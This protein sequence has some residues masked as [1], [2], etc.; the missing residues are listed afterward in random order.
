MLIGTAGG[1]YALGMCF[2]DFSASSRWIL[3]ARTV[4]EHLC[5][6]LSQKPLGPPNVIEVQSSKLKERLLNPVC[7]GR[8]VH[9]SMCLVGVLRELLSSA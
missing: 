5:L 6:L 2:L 8:T 9:G 7:A 3:S 4:L 1:R